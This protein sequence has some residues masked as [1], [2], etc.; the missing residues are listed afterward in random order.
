M[1][2][3]TDGRVSALEDHLVDDSVR[4]DYSGRGQLETG[5]RAIDRRRE[6]EGARTCT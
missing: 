6:T 5:L 3:N 1:G 2:A 4:A